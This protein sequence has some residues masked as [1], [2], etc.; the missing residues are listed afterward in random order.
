MKQINILQ[1]RE[2]F[3]IIPNR[4]II[5][6]KVG[7]VVIMLS[8]MSGCRKK[9]IIPVDELGC[10]I[11][12]EF[13]H[14]NSD[15]NCCDVSGGTLI[16]DTLIYTNE[17][18]NRYLV[19]E[20]QYFISYVTLYNNNGSVI[21]ADQWEPIHYVDTDFPETWNW[22]IGDSF[23]A[24]EYDSLS[25]TFGIPDEKN[26]SFMYVNPPERDMFWPEYLGGGYHSMKLNGKWVEAGQTTQTTPFD[27][28][29]GRGQ[30]YQSYPDSIIGFVPNDF[31][32]TLFQ[33]GFTLI[34]GVI[35]GFSLNMDVGEWFK[36][37]HVFDFDEWGGY[38]MQNQD[39]MQT[40]K[41]N[42]GNV[43]SARWPLG[44]IYPTK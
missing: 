16:F 43:F 11:N 8:S 22:T 20:I 24:G 33:S 27:F 38:I 32:V 28:H 17:A 34:D 12:I 4:L 25:F 3:P 1:F 41:E 5:F 31:K 40:A 2:R 6:F 26:I 13:Q 44:L 36:E 18:G 21:I 10:W 9:V 39:A 35:N 30:I 15:T 19:N 42:G 14:I 37:P 23:P 29:I 7:L